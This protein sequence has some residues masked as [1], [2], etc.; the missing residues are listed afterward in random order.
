MLPA[1]SAPDGWSLSYR[2]LDRHV[3]RGGRRPAAAGVGEG[4]VVALVL[5]T[6]PDH[7]V[8]YAAAPSSVRSRAGVNHRL[9]AAE[10]RRSWSIAPRPSS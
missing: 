5:P 9:T 8:A 10:R 2:D 4:D 1:S 7:V 6:V 3:R